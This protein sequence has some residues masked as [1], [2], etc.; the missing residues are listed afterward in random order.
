MLSI[1]IDG[2]TEAQ[3]LGQLSKVP[4]VTHDTESE[5]YQVRPSLLSVI[6]S[7]F[8]EYRSYSA[9]CPKRLLSH[10][11]HQQLELLLPLPFSKSSSDAVVMIS[12]CFHCCS[13]HPIQ[14]SSTDMFASS[15]NFLK[16][17]IDL[18][19]FDGLHLARHENTQPLKWSLKPCSEK[20][21]WTQRG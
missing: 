20:S 12:V 21:P 10:P 18:S 5:F 11:S 7:L 15:R 8:L 17:Q 13:R 3:K 14:Q 16:P 2:E 19:P 1:F 6:S 9:L 4:N